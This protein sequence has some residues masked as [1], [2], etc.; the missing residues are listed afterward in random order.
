MFWF[1]ST[2][3]CELLYMPRTELKQATHSPAQ[4]FHDSDHRLQPLQIHLANWFQQCHVAVYHV[5][6]RLGY[7]KCPTQPGHLHDCTRSK[8]INNMLNLYSLATPIL[9]HKV[10]SVI[11]HLAHYKPSWK[12]TF[13]HLW[14]LKGIFETHKWLSNYW[15]HQKTKLHR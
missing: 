1:T 10:K 13:C 2:L 4:H 5:S 15:L 11:L 7:T 8:R 6:K 3:D 12:T 9:L 14:A